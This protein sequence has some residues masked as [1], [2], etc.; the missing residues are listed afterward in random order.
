MPKFK[1]RDFSRH[2]YRDPLKKETFREQR[3]RYLFR[4]GS[5]IVF[6]IFVIF[7]FFALR[8]IF[9]GDKFST[10]ELFYYLTNSFNDTPVL[11]AIFTNT[12]LGDWGLFN[13]LRDA[14]L[15]L[16]TVVG[17]VIQGAYNI[18]KFAINIISY[19]TGAGFSLS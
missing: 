10:S 15:G 6:I 13:F 17:I 9:V 18:I 4:K 7:A 3:N 11:N 16:W 14:I 5:F 8:K 19:I 12:S 1:N 2:T